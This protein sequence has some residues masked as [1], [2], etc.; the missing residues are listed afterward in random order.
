MLGK[1]N[2]YCKTCGH[3]FHTSGCEPICNY[4]EDTGHSRAGKSKYGV[5][6]TEHTE[7]TKRNVPMR[8]Y[9]IV[10]SQSEQTLAGNRE[11]KPIPEPVRKTAVKPQEQTEKPQEKTAVKKRTAKDIMIAKS[12]GIDTIVGA[13]RE[14]VKPKAQKPVELCATE[15]MDKEKAM[16]YYNRGCSDQEIGNAVGLSK[17]QIQRWRRRHHLK[18]KYVPALYREDGGKNG[19]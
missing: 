8:K 2:E 14:T 10:L 18:S 13:K 9:G 12:L 15:T 16:A 19:G 11:R 7:L 17:Y 5:G 3:Y 6:C 4:L 1:D